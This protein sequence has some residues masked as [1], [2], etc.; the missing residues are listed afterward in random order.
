MTPQTDIC[1][2]RVR[3][4]FCPADFVSYFYSQIEK[5]LPIIIQRLK[6]HLVDPRRRLHLNIATNNNMKTTNHSFS[7]LWIRKRK[8]L[9]IATWPFPKTVTTVAR[10]PPTEAGMPET[11]P[12]LVVKQ[13]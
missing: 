1:F 7:P 11:L 13:V 3:N 6:T 2:K 12:L 8:V 4:K 5:N 9:L 10:L